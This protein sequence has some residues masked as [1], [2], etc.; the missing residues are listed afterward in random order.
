MGTRGLGGEHGNAGT[1]GR[2]RERGDAGANAGTRERWDA[3]ATYTV[4]THP[5]RT[6]HAV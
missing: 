4:S 2:M 3:G 6:T 5:H 1:Q